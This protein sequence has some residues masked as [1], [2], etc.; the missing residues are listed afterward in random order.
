[1]NENEISYVEH[2][3]TVKV[4]H[5]SRHVGTIVKIAAGFYYITRGTRPAGGPVFPTIDAVKRSIE[6]D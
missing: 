4:F 2:G 6:N 1:M 3:T 5:S